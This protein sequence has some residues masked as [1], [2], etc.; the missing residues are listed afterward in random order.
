MKY[1]LTKLQIK[2]LIEGKPVINGRQKLYADDKV[3]DALKTFDERNLYDK[4][5]VI[6][7]DGGLD[8]KEKQV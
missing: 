4:Y 5:D 1:R 6:L 2:R 3:K 8:I 7:E